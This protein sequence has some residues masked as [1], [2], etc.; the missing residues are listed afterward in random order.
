VSWALL[1]TN[2][3]VTGYLAYGVAT[4][5]IA[6]LRQQGRDIPP[7]VRAIRAELKPFILPL[8]LAA[9]VP[10]VLVNPNFWNIFWCV[11]YLV[12]WWFWRNDED[13]DDDDR[14]KR[15]RQRLA[16]KVAEVGGKLT[17]VPAGSPA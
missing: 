6:L 3:G 10:N 11:G 15:R 9:T 17:I 8:I 16:A 14:W 5:L 7:W 12:M 1:I 4:F 2:V 13:D